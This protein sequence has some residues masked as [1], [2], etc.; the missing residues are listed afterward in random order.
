[1][2]RSTLALFAIVAVVVLS[3]IFLRS[4]DTGT[5]TIA[6][7]VVST[8]TTSTPPPTTSAP[9]ST[10]STTLPDGVEVCDLY[11]TIVTHGRIES[12]DLVE[13]SGLAA[14]RTTPNVLWA[15]NDSRGT[16]A[17]FAFTLTGDDLG[18]HDVPDA[19]A[20][21]WEDMA[22][23]PGPLGAGAYLYAGDIGDNF[24]I[25]GGLVTVYRVPDI[26]PSDLDGSFP[27]STALT[28]RFPDVSH[29][30]EALFIDPLEPALFLVTKDHDEAFVF[31]GSIEPAKGPI[32][33]ELVTTLFLGAEVSG[34]DMSSDGTT[35]ALRGYQF[36]WMWHR[37]SNMSVADMLEGEPC[38]APSPEEPQGEAIAFD[39]ELSYWTVSEGA[40]S[41]IQTVDRER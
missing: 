41:E 9:P 1:M 31:K 37:S 22:A 40:H 7:T 23:G 34:A 30:A 24:H 28:Y 12:P 33:L 19:F 11:D 36:V 35:L 6:S 27:E 26:D 10:S 38:N 15:H 5:S 18:E 25:R 17:L 16:A 29:N 21:D 20:L 2:R 13:A 39:A 4:N 32:D 3:I 14:S 8:T